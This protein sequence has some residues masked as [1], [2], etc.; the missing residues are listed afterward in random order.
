M[1]LGRGSPPP[2]LARPSAD[3]LYCSRVSKAPPAGIA[4]HFIYAVAVEAFF[5]RAMAGRL[6]EAARARIGEAGIDLGQPLRLIYRAEV[7]HAAVAIAASAAFPDRS[8]ED[9][10]YEAGRVHIDAFVESLPG[11]MM[12]AF[13]RQI[14]PSTILEYTATFI[15]LGNNFTESRVR[16]LGRNRMDVWM[17]DVGHVPAWY[18][19][20]LVRG[21]EVANVPGVDVRVASALHPSATFDVSWKD[22]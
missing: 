14:A 1:D 3:R 20:I 12:A 6:D 8:P 5:L 16:P 2:R 21:L 10:Q 11:K 7:F 19:G 9:G 4:D 22:R 17:N 18:R 15:R 13:A